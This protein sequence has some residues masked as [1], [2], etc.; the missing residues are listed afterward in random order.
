MYRPYLRGKQY[1]LLAL[2]E[3]LTKRKISSNFVQPIFEPIKET[4]T[5]RSTLQLFNDENYPLYTVINPA[6][7]DFEKHDS[8]HPI[9]ED[10]NIQYD[11]V[12][13]S[14]TEFDAY[15]V[16]SDSNGVIPIFF[17]V[18]DIAQAT[19]LASNDLSIT[20]SLIKDSS[21]LKRELKRMGHS[22]G[23]IRDA[24]D[25]KERNIDY[26]A[27]PDEFFSD[28]HLYY[29]EEGYEAFSDFSVVGEAYSDSGFA[30]VAVAIHIVY[31]D[32]TDALRIKHF[33]SDSNDDISNPAGK[34]SEAL[35]KLI[36]WAKEQPEK[37]QSIALEEFKSLDLN[38]RYPGLGVVKKLSIMHHIEI[39]NNY[40][41]GK[42]Q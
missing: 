3:L 36:R 18:D 30:P 34:F 40:L 21:R 23:L 31:F 11:A 5:F 8:N 17:K 20:L 19:N 24:F 27:N 13:M 35:N 12:L 37:K 29:L 32:D 38:R 33:V 14:D 2:R 9:L 28:D 7:G 42:R 10:K 1:E 41:S 6:V 39:M 15:S 4:A 22:V 25:K 16:L 26:S